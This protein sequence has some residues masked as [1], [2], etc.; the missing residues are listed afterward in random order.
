M[1]WVLCV[2]TGRSSFESGS[3]LEQPSDGEGPVPEISATF[4]TKSIIKKGRLS[5]R[6]ISFPMSFIGTSR[7]LLL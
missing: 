2:L 7:H 4:E 1:P 5:W 6:P 3:V